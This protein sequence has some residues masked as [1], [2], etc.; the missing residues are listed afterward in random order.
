[1]EVLALLAEGRTNSQLARRLHLSPKTVGHHVSAILEKL[2]VETRA[3]AVANAF[4][5]GIVRV[6][7][8]R[9]N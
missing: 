4:T 9:D 7:E 2:G 3:E 5:M 6:Q 8:R 1:M